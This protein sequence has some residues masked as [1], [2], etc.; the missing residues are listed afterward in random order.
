M[1]EKTFSFFSKKQFSCDEILKKSRHSFCKWHT[2]NLKKQFSRNATAGVNSYKIPY[3][4]KNLGEQ[5]GSTVRSTHEKQ[6]V[7]KY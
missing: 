4:H 7:N 1:Q 2:Q 3:R 5:N 6:K